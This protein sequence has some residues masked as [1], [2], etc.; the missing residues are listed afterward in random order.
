MSMQSHGFS[1]VLKVPNMPIAVLGYHLLFDSNK[2]LFIFRLN[3]GDLQPNIGLFWYF[4]AEMFEHFRV[5]FLF[6]FQMNATI[7]YLIPLTIKFQKQP[8]LFATIL[9]ALI[10]V[11]RSYP[12]VGDLAF[13]LSLIPLWKRSSKCK[14]SN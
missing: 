13:Y 3:H 5:L 14:F 6:T 8:M 11:F 4:F 1:Y 7:L 2:T 10:T 12:C 9:A